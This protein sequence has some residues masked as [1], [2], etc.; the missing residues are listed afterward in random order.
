MTIPHKP[1]NLP[2]IT[3]QLTDTGIAEVGGRTVKFLAAGTLLI[4]DV[5][6]ISA[7]D[8]VAKSTTNADYAAFAGVVVGGQTWDNTGNGQAATEAA[9]VGQTA[10]TVG[11]W[12]IV[13]IDG[14]ARIKSDGAILA[15]SLVIPDAS[16][17]GECDVAG[18][19]PGYTLGKSIEAAADGAT[20]RI[21][22][23]HSY[24]EA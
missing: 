20:G 13:Q 12:V 9:S 10:A 2:F 24:N 17:A 14:I 15:T 3:A 1:T 23:R 16:V 22:I 8:T 19:N 6:Y 21:L 7:A 4:G 18:A 5:V 11:Q